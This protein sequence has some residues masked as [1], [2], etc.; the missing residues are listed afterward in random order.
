MP[1][2]CTESSPQQI[3]TRWSTVWSGTGV[4]NRRGHL[5]GWVQGRPNARGRGE[6]RDVVGWSALTVRCD[7]MGRS[8]GN[9]VDCVAEQGGR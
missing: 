3:G 8:D 1:R 9:A 6:P 2:R 7:R 4:P 5:A